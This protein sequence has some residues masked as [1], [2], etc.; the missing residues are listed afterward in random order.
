MAWNIDF[1]GFMGCSFGLEIWP[2]KGG[3]LFCNMFLG[4]PPPPQKKNNNQIAAIQ[5]RNGVWVSNFQDFLL[6]N[7]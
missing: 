3:S 1:H 2:L 7:S 5:K 6:T 4:S